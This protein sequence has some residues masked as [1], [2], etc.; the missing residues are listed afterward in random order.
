[1]IRRILF[2]F[3]C[4]LAASAS[5]VVVEVNLPYKT[6][7]LK[8]GMLFTD[9]AVKSFNTSAGTAV[10]VVNKDLISLRTSLLPDDVNAR[11]KDLT[12]V[13]T[14]EEQEA[15]KL[16]EAADRK[17]AAD[18]ADRRQKV[19]EDEAQAVR[20][21]NRNLNV[22]VAEQ[23]AVKPDASLEEVA[24][25]AEERAKSY[26]KYQDDPYSNIGAVVGSDILLRDPEPV[27]GWPGRYRVEGT[28]NRQFI[29]NQASGFGRG[30]KEFEV[31]IQTEAGKKP[32]LVEVRI[33]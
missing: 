11:L 6:L 1:M 29:N 22:K 2:P 25:F 13:L 32:K 3:V 18:T 19:A 16:Q 33:K 20:A 10:L 26:F 12:P 9:A 8:D 17:K 15:E 27:P 14:K 7:R 23:T 5:A 30:S 4:L 28:A 24:K 21:A 31:L